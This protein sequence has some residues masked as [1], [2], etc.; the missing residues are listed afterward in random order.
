MSADAP[1]AAVVAERDLN[2][3][4]ARGLVDGMKADV[5]DLGERLGIAYTGRA[6]VALGYGS[7]D[8]MCDAE[9]PGARLRLPREQRAEQVQSLA[10]MG[11][12]TRA[13][14]SALGVHHDTVASD[15]KKA[16]V[17]NPTVARPS[18]VQSLD[19]RTRPASQ[20]PRPEPVHVVHTTTT[21][22]E[23]LDVDPRT[24]ELLDHMPIEQHPDYQDESARATETALLDQQLEDHLSKT[25]NRFLHNL[26]RGISGARFLI[27][28][29][30]NR[31]AETCLPDSDDEYVLLAF[32]TDMRAWF[33]DVERARAARTAPLLHLRRVQ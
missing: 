33:A 5:A 21:T 16:T 23:H 9:F 17:G 27:E 18:T 1:L 12:S 8:A 22:T 29:S 15:L 3:V 31:V 19:G 28:L 25:D 11:L 7:W 13:I 32:L 14:G 20:P 30:P 6:W 26:A 2:E 4:E 10:A 24:G